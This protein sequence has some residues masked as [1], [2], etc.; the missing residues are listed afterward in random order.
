MVRRE[1]LHAL[2]LSRK[3]SGEADRLLTLFTRPH[4]ILRVYANG[5]RRIPSRRGGHLEP[6]THV[7]C[8]VTG[9]SG[10]WHLVTAE[11]IDLYS[12]LH[13]DPGAVAHAQILARMITGLFEQEDPQPQLFDALQHSLQVL[14]GLTAQQ[15]RVVE[16]T[17]V[18]FG[19]QCAGLM[20]Q[21]AAC[22]VCGEKKPHDA[23]VLNAQWGGWRCL[24]CH[25][26]F[27]AARASLPPRLLAAL[28]WLA[29]YPQRAVQ[30][31]L[32]NDQSEQLVAAARYY[33]TSVLE[34]MVKQTPG[35]RSK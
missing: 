28:R 30:L 25:D 4:G 21:L 18:L 9:S 19:L 31:T 3:D 33:L 7:L 24:S 35:A 23:V 10:R 1:K 12:D 27:A 20:P 29:R 17:L 6:L 15:R 14:P 32:S 5:V 34:T 22:Q 26:S 2:I 16:T 11:P 8:I 13:A